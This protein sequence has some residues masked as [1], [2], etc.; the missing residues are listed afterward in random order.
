MCAVSTLDVYFLR[1][2][3]DSKDHIFA[4]SCHSGSKSSNKSS[5][6]RSKHID[7]VAYISCPVSSSTLGLCDQLIKDF[8][9]DQEWGMVGNGD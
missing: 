4:P 6:L 5:L 1:T 3:S 7:V 9:H 8:L 2:T